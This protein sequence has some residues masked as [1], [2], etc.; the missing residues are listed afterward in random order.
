MT[1]AEKNLIDDLISARGTHIAA[2]QESHDNPLSLQAIGEAVDADVLIWISIDS[3]SLTPDGQTFAPISETRV[4]IIDVATGERLWPEEPEGFSRVIR[5]PTQQ[6]M[7]PT[8][9][10]EVLEAQQNLAS[11]TGIG[12]AQL[13]FKREMTEDR[14]RG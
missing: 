8:T 11:W 1:E 9:R 12:V 4:K 7:A 2:R 13:F 5:M 6:G 10:A 14:G 3:F